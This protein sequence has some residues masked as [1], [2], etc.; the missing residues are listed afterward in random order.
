MKQ[1]FLFLLIILLILF[2]GYS[3][4]V[5]TIRIDGISPSDFVGFIPDQ[6]VLNFDST[7]RSQ[8]D[9]NRA[10]NEGLT[11]VPRLDHLT[12]IYPV[13][14]ILQKYP[15]TEKKIYQGK[16]IDLNGWFTI[17]FSG[18]VD[19]E[20]VVQRYKQ[21]P[22]VIDAQPIGIHTVDAIPNDYNF[23]LQ[24]HL[25]QTND[26]DVDAPEAWDIQTGN[27]SIIVGVMDT[28]VRYF[29]QDL[30]GA[31]AS[32]STPLNSR[33]NMWINQT[34]LIAGIPDG[35]DNDGNGY[36]DDWIGWDFVTGITFN[37]TY[38]AIAGEDYST[39]DNDPR[40]FN[41][42][43]T[44]CAGNVGALNNNAYATAAVSGG[45][46]NGT[47]QTSGNGVKVLALRI[48]YSV[49]YYYL[50]YIYQGEVGLINMAAAANAFLY[51]ADNGAR[52]VSC[53]WGSS[54][55]AG[56]G[57]AVD[58]YLASGGLI[59]K[60]AGNSGNTTAD[61]ICSRSDLNIISVAA[62][63]TLDRKADF[64]NYGSWVDVSAPGTGIWSSYHVHTQPSNDYIAALDGTSM[65]S[66][67]AASTAALIWSAN[68][69]LSA[70]EVR[71]ILFNNSDN[72]DAANPGY[73]GLL[74]A[75]RV[76]AFSPLMDPSLPVVLSSFTVREDPTGIILE[77]ETKSE[78]ENMGFE[79]I[80]KSE[81][82]ENYT[83]IASYL[84]ND[85]LKGL[86]NSTTGKKYSY[87][88]TRADP[89]TNYCYKLVDV[90][91]NGIRTEHG[92]V[93][94]LVG[95]G[96]NNSLASVAAEQFY[97]FPNFPNPFNGGT[98]IAFNL[99]DRKTGDIKTRV[100]VYN[101]VGEEV[102]TLLDD[103]L[104]SGIYKIY[105]D[106]KDAQGILL[107]SGVYFYAIQSGDFRQ[108][109]KMI[110]LK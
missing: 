73:V 21:I 59:F 95:S 1:K 18:E 71:Q 56:L 30:G 64:S 104:A 14:S 63:D 101:M 93:S 12:S 28:G 2:S 76:N 88:D 97:L 4:E 10:E 5:K 80:R 25:T 45:W 32:L 7:L 55:T 65:A 102:R 99:P 19:V 48:G 61:Y 24:W 72:I 110:M 3:Q 57:A 70:D 41:G 100:L 89:K 20:R 67:I 109:R 6:I 9:R 29:H 75:G 39:P 85:Q 26:H 47:L 86:G 15:P 16:L 36:V 49:D 46:G 31:T 91:I 107:A 96:S 62:T 78:I 22:G 92:P 40:D 106:G 34:E 43:G 42:H 38:R 68:P 82:Q 11:G 50:G 74:G 17:H 66:P 51:A 37:L 77:W 90:D 54:N 94:I 84:T 33:G 35:I 53:S 79:I 108:Y 103:N 58:Y 98:Y 87:T 27:S 44:H 105:W 23:N 83:T 69:S 13:R 52:I 60:S 8:V 81:H